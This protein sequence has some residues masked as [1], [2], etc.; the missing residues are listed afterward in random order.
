MSQ[1]DILIIFGTT[2]SGKS[3]IANKVADKNDAAIINSDSLQIYKDL[4]I[5][6]DRPSEQNI[7]RYDHRL[8]G[9][10]SFRSE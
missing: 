1:R 10:L 3:Y 4:Y 2:A 9:I 8:Y 5:L 6:T 7:S